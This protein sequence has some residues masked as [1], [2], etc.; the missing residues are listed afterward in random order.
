MP[1]GEMPISEDIEK[2]AEGMIIYPL[3]SKLLKKQGILIIVTSYERHNAP[4]HLHLDYSL[5][6]LLELR[7]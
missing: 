3:P 5:I 7:A 1:N 6:S 4:N 2:S